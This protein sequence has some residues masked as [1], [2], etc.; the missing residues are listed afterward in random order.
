MSHSLRQEGVKTSEREDQEQ[1]EDEVS[2]YQWSAILAEEAQQGMKG[3][4][5]VWRSA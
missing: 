2:L 3:R 4:A 5:I 1:P